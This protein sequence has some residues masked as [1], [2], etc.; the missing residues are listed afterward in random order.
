MARFADDVGI[1][2]HSVMNY[3]F[4]AAHWP[5]EHRMQGVSIDIHRILM[6]HPDRFELIRNPPFNPHYGTHRWTQ[7]AARRVRGW[8]VQHRCRSRRR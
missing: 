7:D 3:R 6:G 1:C 8:N 2:V 4:T 5:P